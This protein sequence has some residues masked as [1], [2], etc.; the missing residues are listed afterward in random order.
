MELSSAGGRDEGSDMLSQVTA[1]TLRQMC[2][3]ECGGLCEGGHAFWSARP[4][5]AEGET[6]HRSGCPIMTARPGHCLL[7]TAA[8][9]P[10]PERLPYCR[11]GSYSGRSSPP[12][13]PH[14]ET[15]HCLGSPGSPVHTRV[16]TG[17]F[18]DHCT[19]VL[20]H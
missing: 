18:T 14:E 15:L 6:G 3:V 1:P 8:S 17:Q 7:G 10:P 5:A 2:V 13:C 20:R 11:T 19:V 9:P 12:A 4:K 16:H